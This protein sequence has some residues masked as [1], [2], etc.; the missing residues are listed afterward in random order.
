[1]AA[2]ASAKAPEVEAKPKAGKQTNCL[3]C[4]KVIK[5]IRRYYR[6]GKLYC[7]KKCWRVYLDKTKAEAGKEKK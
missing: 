7:T 4:N 5:K 3:G 2:E 6:D 1:M